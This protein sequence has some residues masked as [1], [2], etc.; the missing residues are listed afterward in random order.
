MNSL[1]SSTAPRAARAVFFSAIALLAGPVCAAGGLDFDRTFASRGEPAQLHFKAR[2]LL[3]SAS[4]EVELWRDG[5]HRLRRRTDDAIDTFLE[6]PEKEIEWNM[7][8]LDLKRKIRTEVNRSNLAR[9]GHIADWFSL[10][11]ALNRPT[12]AYR[13]TSASAP[14]G[15][16]DAIAPCKWYQIERDGQA[17]RICWSGKLH[18]PLLIASAD[19][20]PVWQVTMAE[21]GA[22]ADATFRIRDAGFV[23][24][25]ANGDISGD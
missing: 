25:D 15:V 12:G 18:L 1:F 20:K 11:H 5:N 23:R 2:Y 9:V 19:G 22:I 8:V 21:T 16:A 17:S 6:K 7:V 4:H 24:N 13:L 14:A 10:A 3:G